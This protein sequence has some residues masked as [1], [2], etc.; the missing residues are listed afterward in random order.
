[1]FTVTLSSIPKYLRLYY[2]MTSNTSN[3]CAPSKYDSKNK[4]CFTGKQLLQMAMAY[5][6][7]VSKIK[8]SPK[9]QSRANLTSADLI[10]L[11]KILSEKSEDKI[12]DSDKK[13]LLTELKQR[14][15]K[16]CQGDEYCLTQQAFMNEIV[17]E[18][19][20]L[21]RTVGP[22]KSKEWLSTSEIEN[23]MT[24]Y[25]PIYPD[26]KFIGAVPLDCDEYAHCNLHNINY[27]KYI[28]N[29]F[30]KFG[31]V[32]NHDRYGESG[33]HWVALYMDVGAGEVNYCDSMGKKPLEN[34]ST[35]IDTFTEFYKKSK[36][37]EPVLL[38][39]TKSYQT[40]GS[41]CGIYAC[42]FIIRRLSGESFKSVVD[43]PLTFREINSCR[44]VYFRNQPSTYA[45]H[46]KCDPPIHKSKA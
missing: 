1:M 7:Y 16:V 13:Y 11:D 2:I 29:G 14:F 5:N 22:A 46:P 35:V 15:E 4:T 31:V 32:F 43:N 40:D 36:G 27:E 23:V 39:N 17:G 3:I 34:I 37:S 33:S 28:N 12:S 30:T 20:G 9:P 25:E 26:F 10:K 42:N 8:L 18:M 38:I 45:P 21:F 24:Q 6:L 44:N 41:E 19:E